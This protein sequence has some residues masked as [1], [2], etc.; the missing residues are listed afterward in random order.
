MSSKI[1]VVLALLVLVI[2][3][4]AMAQYGYLPPDGGNEQPK[5]L[6]IE[7]DSSCEG[8]VVTI[9]RRNTPETVSGAQ[10]TVTD[11]TGAPIFSGETDANGQITFE[12]CGM[13]VIIY[14]SKSG[15]KSD[16][17]TH[18]L[19]PCEQCEEERGPVCGDGTCD[20]GE[21]ADNCPEDCP[22]AAA[23][24]ETGE[25]PTAPPTEPQFECTSDADCADVEYCAMAVGA[26]GGTCEP[27]TGECGYAENHVWV[28]YECGDEAGCPSCN[29]GF[30]CKD[31]VC[32][33]VEEPEEEPPVGA[34]EEPAG[35]EEPPEE[36]FPWL[37]LLGFL[38][39]LAI[40]LRWLFGIGAPGRR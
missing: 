21:T 20:Q 24:P 29:V 37:Y 14:T 38:I 11:V 19:I 5:P 15:W 9:Y 8:N 27:V 2:S 3:P 13:T 18:S 10:V 35:E 4:L 1:F 39:L 23:P 31:H 40:L 6:E 22:P 28:Q 7:L 33:A 25:E 26:A 16:E 30:E 17:E 12:G 34:P 36:G 32:V